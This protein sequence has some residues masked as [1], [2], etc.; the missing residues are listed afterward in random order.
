MT[1]DPP[2][3]PS[4]RSCAGRQPPPVTLSEAK[5]LWAPGTV[6]LVVFTEGRRWCSGRRWRWS[7]S[8]RAYSAAAQRTDVRVRAPSNRHCRCRSVRGRLLEPSRSPR[9][10]EAQHVRASRRSQNPVPET[11]V[12]KTLATGDTRVFVLSDRASAWPCPQ[13]RKA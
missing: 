8:P 2:A 10:C 12:P 9:A 3:G 5:G 6:A 7:M 11:L 4:R 1:R 13:D